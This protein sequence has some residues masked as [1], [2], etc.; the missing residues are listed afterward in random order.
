MTRRQRTPKERFEQYDEV[1]RLR[2]EGKNSSTISSETGL[3][4][5]YVYVIM[6][7]AGLIRRSANAEERPSYL[8]KFSESYDNDLPEKCKVLFLKGLEPKEI[9][10]KLAIPLHIVYLRLR[11]A[12]VRVRAEHK[13]RTKKSNQNSERYSMVRELAS[14]G[15]TYKTIGER[16]GIT[17][18]RVAQ[19]LKTFDDFQPRKVGK[20]KVKNEEQ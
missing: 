18:Q 3:C 4:L 9:A 2:N 5:S 11:K 12:G 16:M 8:R 1:V 20:K 15:M 19:M 7:D 10:E 13:N 6:N 17:K 14:T